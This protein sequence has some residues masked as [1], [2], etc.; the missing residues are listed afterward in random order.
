MVR[1]KLSSALLSATLTTEDGSSPPKLV[2][3]VGVDVS[4]VDTV[5]NRQYTR[6]EAETAVKMAVGGL[7]PSKR[8]EWGKKSVPEIANELLDESVVAVAVLSNLAVDPGTRRMGI[9]RGTKK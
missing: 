1:R 4:L 9:G 8:R 3:I 7:P 6:T 5:Q 2:G